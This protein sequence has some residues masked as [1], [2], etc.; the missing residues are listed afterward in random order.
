MIEKNIGCEDL[1]EALC[2][3]MNTESWEWAS[4]QPE[5]EVNEPTELR[6]I[7]SQIYE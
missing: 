6:E 7:C 3:A 4:S 2:Q 1:D 5:E